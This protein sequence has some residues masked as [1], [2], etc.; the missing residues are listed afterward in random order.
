MVGS[1]R[2]CETVD[3]I[4]NWLQE[5]YLSEKEALMRTLCCRASEVVVLGRVFLISKMFLK[6][7]K[8]GNDVRIF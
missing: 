8:M 3:S 7:T 4:P 2:E 5:F 6:D 1:I